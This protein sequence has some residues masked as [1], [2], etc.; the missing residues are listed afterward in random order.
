VPGHLFIG[1][2]VSFYRVQAGAVTSSGRGLRAVDAPHT[3][4]TGRWPA[5]ADKRQQQPQA[6][7]ASSRRMWGQC[8]QMRSSMREA[9]HCAQH[10]VAS[11]AQLLGLAYRALR[12]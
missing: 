3:A 6:R 2:T 11:R 9:H 8:L 12:T 4:R 5:M 7:P 1:E 10:A